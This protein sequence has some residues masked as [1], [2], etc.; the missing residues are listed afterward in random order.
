MTWVFEPFQI[1]GGLAPPAAECNATTAGAGAEIPY[2]ADY[3]FWK[4]G[5]A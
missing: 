5:G 3:Y 2:T 1:A 4:K